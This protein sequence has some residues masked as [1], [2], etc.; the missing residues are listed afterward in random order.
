M[1][2]EQL[3][4]LR[5]R[6]IMG[7]PPYKKDEVMGTL[8]RDIGTPGLDELKAVGSYAPGA[9]SIIMS[10]ETS[11]QLVEHLLERMR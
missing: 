6:L 9:S 1:N 11:L 5:E 4:K 3:V 7:D 8:R 2:R 10:L